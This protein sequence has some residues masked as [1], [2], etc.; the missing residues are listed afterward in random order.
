MYLFFPP[1]SSIEKFKQMPQRRQASEL[2]NFSA[3]FNAAF[4]ESENSSS[5]PHSFD[6]LT[7]TALSNVHLK[8]RNRYHIPDLT[9][10]F[11][12][13]EMVY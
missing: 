9:G 2:L 6:S 7:V 12:G 13:D 8:T 5:V 1:K 10:F 4:L 3:G 11:S